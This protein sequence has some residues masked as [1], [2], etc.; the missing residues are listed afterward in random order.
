MARPLNALIVALAVPVLA[1]VGWLAW[2]GAHVAPV[3][4]QID[5]ADDV[6]DRGEFGTAMLDEARAANPDTDIQLDEAR[7]VL[8]WKERDVNGE[9]HLEGMY[10]DYLKAAP[11]DRM[12][13]MHERAAHI[14]APPLPTTLAE[15]EPH[16]VA[17]VRERIGFELARIA[18]SAKPE[19]ELIA[20]PPHVALTDDLWGVL[21]YETDDQFI[22]LDA[23]ALTRWGAKFEDLW[24][25]VLEKLVASSTSAKSSENHGVYDLDYGDQNSSARILAPSVFAKLIG[26]DVV[27]AMPKESLFLVTSKADVNAVDALTDRVSREWDRGA[28]NARLFAVDMKGAVRP[29]D[30]A[31][32][33][34]AELTRAAAQRDEQ[35]QR[36]ALRA[37]YGEAEDTPFVATLKRIKNPTTKDEIEF[38]VQTAEVPTLIPKAN[39]IVFRHVDPA[40]NE[41]TTLACGTWERVY[42]LMKS[43]WKETPLYPKRWF[44]AEVPTAKELAALGCDN[45][46]LK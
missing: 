13:L 15:A 45:P 30:D 20:A 10:R 3:S 14:K 36:D 9:Y 44:A 33:S 26:G 42:A 35:L 18:V 17:V 2:R 25:K 12:P 19:V 37:K 34:V 39:W 40:H 16:L 46:A 41:A 29:Y 23:I 21:A 7:F 6:I 22:R 31:R 8:V 5:A 28:Q 38:A 4:E 11:V 1:G 27:V 32:P 24:P 43:R